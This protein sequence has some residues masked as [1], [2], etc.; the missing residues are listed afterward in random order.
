MPEPWSQ[1]CA[2]G[3]VYLWKSVLLIVRQT[4]GQ[5]RVI[6]IIGHRLWERVGFSGGN[7]C[8]RPHPCLMCCLLQAYLVEATSLPRVLSSAGVP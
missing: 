1:G 5:E 7:L 8:W 2:A 3:V 6:W 4:V